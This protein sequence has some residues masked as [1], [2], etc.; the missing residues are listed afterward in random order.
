MRNPP[1]ISKKP[2]YSLAILGHPGHMHDK[3]RLAIAKRHGQIK[4]L[5]TEKGMGLADLQLAMH[6]LSLPQGHTHLGLLEEELW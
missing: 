4:L 1:K 3:E 2:E 6:V 5:K